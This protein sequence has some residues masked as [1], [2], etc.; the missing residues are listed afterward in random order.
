MIR[1]TRREMLRYGPVTA[2]ALP[3]PDEEGPV[4]LDVIKSLNIEPQ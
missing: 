3:A 4:W 1:P 2:A